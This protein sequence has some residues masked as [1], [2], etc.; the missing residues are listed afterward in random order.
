MERVHPTFSFRDS[1]SLRERR[2]VFLEAPDPAPATSAEDLVARARNLTDSELRQAFN[3]YGNALSD[4][5][6]TQLNTDL[7]ARESPL[8]PY[9]VSQ[10]AD[11]NNQLTLA[12]EVLAVRYQGGVLEVLAKMGAD[13]FCGGLVS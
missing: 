12:T 11:G 1:G 2:L 6:V 5:Q 10:D 8:L 13:T 3:N 4:E 9:F 7:Q